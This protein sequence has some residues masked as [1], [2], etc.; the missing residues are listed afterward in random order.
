MLDF[1]L[2]K[3]L[4]QGGT[5][6]IYAL[7]ILLLLWRPQGL[8]GQADMSARAR[9][10]TSIRRRA[11][12]PSATACA[13]GSRCPGSLALAFY[14]AFPRYLGFGTELLITILFALSLDLALG[15]A[16]IVTLGHAAFFGAGAYTVGMLAHARHLERADHRACSLAAVVAALIGLAL[17]P[18]AAAHHRPDA[19]DADALHHGAARGGRQHGRTTY[20]GGFD[21]LPSLPIPPLF[22]MF[23]FNP[24]YPEHAVSLRARRAVRL[25]RVRAH[26]G[27]FAVRAEPDRHPREHR[28][29]CTRSARR[30]ARRLVVCYTISAAI[31]GIAGGLWAQANA[32]VNLA[33]LGLDRAATVLIILVLGGY[34][35]LYGAFVGAVAYMVLSHFLS[36]VYPTAWQ[37]G[38]GLLLVVIALFARNGIL[39]LGDNLMRRFA[40]TAHAAMTALL[41][42]RSLSKNFGALARRR[43]T[44][45]FALEP[46]ARHALIGPNG[47]G[48]TT[49]INLLTGVLPPSA[50]TG[51]AQGPGHHRRASRPSA[52]SSASPAPS[53]STGC[54]A[55]SRCWRTS[56]S[57][58]PSGS[59]PRRRCCGRP[60]CARDVIDEAMQLL[61]TLK[62]AD[63]AA[64]RRISELPYGRQRL[65][66][67][68]IA[69]GLEA[70]GAAARRAGR[71]RAERREPHHPRRHRR[72]AEAASACSS[73]TTTWTWC[74]AS[75][76][77][78][79]VLVRGAMF[80]EGTP[81]EIGAN[82]DVRAVYLGQAHP[83][84]D[85]LELKARV[86]RLRRDRRAGGHQSRARAGRE[87]QRDRPQRRRQDHAARDRHGPHHAAQ[88]RGAARRQE[89]QPRA[90]LSRAPLAGL[91]F[92]PQEREIF[93]SLTVRENLEVGARPGHWTQERV[94]ELFPNL[95][96]RLDNM[97]NQLSGG[98]QQM[99]SIARA[100]L[101]N[102]TRA[103]DGRA[104][105]GARAG[106]RRDADR[107]AGA[108]ARESG[109]SIILVE[110]NSRVA[111]DFSDA[112]GG[113]GQGPHRL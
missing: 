24:L 74:S 7:T 33:T 50:G 70:R 58:S 86:G 53:R 37:L 4:P 87:H 39:G 66:E 49:F 85:A 19:A 106:D 97:G 80:A 18:R 40:Q 61:D 27:L 95:K 5:L 43:A 25:L 16:G 20:T 102:P 56:T 28:C 69:L 75:R 30:C 23:E 77:R 44:S 13:G 112:H 99:L 98:E 90:G 100:L 41:E 82:P 22:G 45:T 92:V 111:L 78:I 84:L 105:R 21:G 72:A 71:R 67:L 1:V 54:S 104:D 64:A 14:F 35:R 96:E 113:H 68:A 93:P 46:G 32:Y 42:T 89:P 79:T 51:A 94:F 6:F 110:Q 81:K 60:A 8:F 57:R 103:A 11:R 12:S 63:D 73:S 88:G 29:A 59:A 83:W 34:G 17:G 15:Y 10:R 9:P 52:S 3:Y 109:L 48:K 101:T 2:K 31:A 62:L 91:G 47:A 108:A 55:A 76:K 65:V 38:L 107:G 26:A 36:K